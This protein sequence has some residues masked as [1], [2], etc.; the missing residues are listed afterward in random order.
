MFPSPRGLVD[1][2]A[3]VLRNR[4]LHGGHGPHRQGAGALPHVPPVHQH[5]LHAVTVEACPDAPAV[6]ERLQQRG[7]TTSRSLP[8]RGGRLTPQVD[9]GLHN[10]GR[11]LLVVG[12]LARRRALEEELVLLLQRREL[13]LVHARRR[14]RQREGVDQAP[15]AEGLAAAAGGEDLLR[16][17]LLG[18]LALI[19]LFLQRARQ[20]QPEDP[21][22]PPLADAPGPLPRLDV[23]H[24]IPIGV[25]ENDPIGAD[26]VQA[27]ATD[28]G[29]KDHGKQ[30]RVTIELLYRSNT[31]A[32]GGPAVHPQMSVT[33]PFHQLPK[34]LQHPHRL[35]KDQDSVALGKPLA[36]GLYQDFHL[37]RPLVVPHVWR[38]QAAVGFTQQEVRVVAQPSADVDRVHDV[39]RLSGTTPQM[40]C[41]LRLHEAQVG[42]VLLRGQMA[43]EHLLLLLWQLDGFHHL[44][45][46]PP[47]DGRL[48]HLSQRRC[49]LVRSGCSR[50][51]HSRSAARLDGPRHLLSEDRQ[52]AQAAR[53]HEVHQRPQLLQIVVDWRTC[54]YD[55][56]RSVE[57][58]RDV[59]AKSVRVPDLLALI[60][61]HHCPWDLHNV[62]AARPQHLVG[63]DG[64]ALWT[65]RRRERL[66]PRLLLQLVNHADVQAR[67]PD[68]DLLLPLA[69]QRDRADHQDA[70]GGFAAQAARVVQ[71][72]QVGDRLH[73][74]A[75][76]QVVGQDAP[77]L[78]SVKV[79]EP[80]HALLLV[81]VERLPEPAWAPQALSHLCALLWVWRLRRRHRVGRGLARALPA[82]L[83]AALARPDRLPQLEGLALAAAFGPGA[84]PCSSIRSGLCGLYPALGACCSW[85]LG[86]AH[87]RGRSGRSGRRIRYHE[88][89]AAVVG[90]AGPVG[91][92][93]RDVA[94][95]QTRCRAAPAQ[96]GD[97]GL[98]RPEVLRPHALLV[99]AL[100][101]H[102][103]ATH[104]RHPRLTRGQGTVEFGAGLK[105]PQA[106]SCSSFERCM[107]T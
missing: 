13:R 77:L 97:A 31:L 96:Y 7:A 29:R 105:P 86:G 84:P 41:L 56:V 104:V 22:L 80:P 99:A 78:V 15:P 100:Q 66:L 53:P 102:Y 52:G 34:N 65:A 69:Q 61:D 98:R 3:G 74:L 83:G 49:S 103:P 35:H 85:A 51:L 60:Q 24:G 6:E 11:A 101:P 59:C 106:H 14:R 55:A 38:L 18:H 95:P 71:R 89:V 70:L 87:R 36:H 67:V 17:L 5:P 64:D 107:L 46:R 4:P 20:Q 37:A 50:R 93:Q 54:Q 43:Q 90:S 82:L 33:L 72:R 57:G 28:A 81:R 42:R 40:G 94:P 68:P 8:A 10:V 1:A 39:P 63:G 23:G 92:R 45:L 76:T 88:V 26:D 27:Y 48:G 47:Q 91:P 79:P 2:S 32:H 16:Q 62:A 25:K 19:D 12:L 73:S 9:D 58:L 75:Q 30:V 44:R 21:H